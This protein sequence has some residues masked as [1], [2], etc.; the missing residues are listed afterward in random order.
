MKELS[1]EGNIASSG[2]V[3]TRKGSSISSSA[4]IR[5]VW[6]YRQGIDRHERV[7]HGARD[8]NVTSFDLDASASLDAQ[9]ARAR[10]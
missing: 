9:V 5:E 4:Q 6:Q 2:R 3:T 1:R 8:I 10:Q 7:D